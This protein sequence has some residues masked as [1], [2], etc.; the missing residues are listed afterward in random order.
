M[1]TYKELLQ[2]QDEKNGPPSSRCA[3]LRRDKQN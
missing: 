3:G 2:S 1:A